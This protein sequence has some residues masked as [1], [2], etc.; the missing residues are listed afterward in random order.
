MD[1]DAI[2]CSLTLSKSVAVERAISILKNTVPETQIFIEELQI[3]EPFR[4]QYLITI[5]GP[6]VEFVSA[7]IKTII[8]QV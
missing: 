4:S 8:E 1:I 2:V 6:N 5:S 7:I 3:L